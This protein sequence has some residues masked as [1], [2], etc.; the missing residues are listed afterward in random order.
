MKRRALLVCAAL[1]LLAAA[2]VSADKPQGRD[3][4]LVWEAPGLDTVSL[5]RV[6]MLPAASYDRDLSHEKMV[7]GMLAA[8]LRGSGHRWLSTTSTRTLLRTATGNDSLL[9]GVREEILDHAR[10]DSLSAIQVCERLRSDAILAVRVDRFEQ[11]KLDVGQSGKP[12]TTVQA[13][14]TLM[15]AHGRVLWTIS[16]S[17]VGEG[18]YQ[19]PN[20][21]PYTTP[22]GGVNL[23]PKNS[24]PGPPSYE[25]VLQ[26]LVARWG[27]RFPRAAAP[28]E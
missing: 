6:A 23:N 3:L 26:K 4:D 24:N 5:G 16:G 15:D 7:E 19:S 20:T 25:E 17:E 2:A 1:G 8:A 27:Q 13:K 9:N 21:N 14:A 28:S 10:L 18:P 22:A 12:S 11:V